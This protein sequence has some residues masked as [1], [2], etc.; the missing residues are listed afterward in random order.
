MKAVI[1]PLIAKYYTFKKNGPTVVSSP[2]P[3]ETPMSTPTYLILGATGGMGHA[4]CERLFV[5]GDHRDL[6]SLQGAMA[7]GRR[8]AREIAEAA[9]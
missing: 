2:A 8:A 1:F 4:L 3:T 9:G 5:C 7:S 6:A